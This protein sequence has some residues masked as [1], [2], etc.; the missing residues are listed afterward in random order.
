MRFIGRDDP[1]AALKFGKVFMDTVYNFIAKN[2]FAAPRGFD[3]ETR[4]KLMPKYR[5]YKIAYTV[6]DGY[7]EIMRLLHTSKEQP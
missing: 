2:P 6:G 1:E 5:A 3:A 7:I 4:D